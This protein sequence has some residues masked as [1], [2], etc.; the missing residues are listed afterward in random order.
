MLQTRRCSA[1]L[2]AAGALLCLSLP[3]GAAG[4]VALPAGSTGSVVPLPTGAAGS[5]APL[6]TSDYLTRPACHTPAPAHAGCLAMELVPRTAEARARTHPL[7]I[8]RGGPL[9]APSPQNGGDGLRPTDLR[10]AYFRGEAPEAPASAPQTI[11]LVDAYNDP[12]AEADLGVYDKEFGIEACTEADGCFEQVN[13]Q[14]ERGHPPFPTSEAQRGEQLT[15]CEDTKATKA[16]REAACAMVEEAEGWAVEIST[17]IETANAICQKHCHIVLVEATTD[18]FEDLEA[19]EETAVRIGHEAERTGTCATKVEVCDTE[20][21]N[22]W[23]GPE[24][25]LDS[26]AFDHPGTVITASAGDDGYLNWTEAA[27]AEAAKEAYYSG[28]DYPASSPNVVAVGGTRLGLSAAGAWKEETVWNDDPRG[29]E[30]NYGAGGGGCSTQFSAPEWQRD[31]ADWAKVGC[32]TGADAKRAVADVSA[33][34]DPYSGV[35]VYDSVPDPHEELVGK[36]TETIKDATPLSWWPIGGTS[37]ASPIVA[38]MFALAGGSHGVEYPAQTLYEHLQTGL[39]HPVTSGGNGECDD[40]YSEDPITHTTCDGSMNPFSERFAFDCGKGVLIC[41]AG[42]G[43]NGPAGVGTPDGI[44]ALVPLTEAERKAIE[45][46]HAEEAK[47]QAEAE[48]AAKLKA[49][50]EAAAKAKEG[51]QAEGP[52]D[53]KPAPG[54]TG[55]K[56]NGGGS[57]TTGE[58]GA[59]GSGDSGAGGAG[60]DTSPHSSAIVT[61]PTPAHSGKGSAGRGAVRLSKLALTARASTVF[62]SGLPTISQVAFAFTLSAPARVRVTLSRLVRVGGRVRWASAPGGFTLPAAR[63][64]YR[65][66]LRGRGTL[67]AGR[68]RLTLTPVHGAARSLTFQLG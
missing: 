1:L 37:V 66:H 60:A 50:E 65:T 61:G 18:S 59:G 36:E 48:A 4:S 47:K 26:P 9:Q 54:E 40:L 57:L 55:S 41:N 20:V 13:Q 27:E 22:S 2:F 56:G 58:A 23:G 62:A 46:K 14:G 10:A 53:E 25:V 38:S 16:T 39:L 8:T 42:P 34:A 6:P 63:G 33:D 12:S 32:G 15:V 35:A 43:Y 21:S 29:G 49:E 52:L 5:V 28:P 11:A 30:E 3:V 44:G 45:A 68:Y 17:D 7:G 24:P 64:H 31:V 51:K 67:P 19:A